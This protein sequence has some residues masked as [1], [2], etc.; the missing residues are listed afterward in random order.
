MNRNELEHIIR[1]AGDIAKVQEVII[2]GSQSVLGQYPELSYK[3]DNSESREIMI[4]SMEA[5]IMIPESEEKTELVETIIGELSS[6]HDTFGYYAQG[7]DHT[8]SNLPEGWRDRLIK[9]CN[10]NTNHITGLCLEIH[11]LTISKLYAGREKDTEFF[12]AAVKNGLVSMRILLQRLSDT[13]MSEE[14]KS[15]IEQR[16]KKGFSK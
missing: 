11:D 1:A 15:I 13:P 9:I 5:D 7:V 16:I 3:A 14:R 6:F 8:T 10:E 4:R 12:H 2:L